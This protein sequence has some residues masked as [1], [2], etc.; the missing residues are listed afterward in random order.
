MARKAA[1]VE[2]EEEEDS[3]GGGGGGADNRLSISRCYEEELKKR[4]GRSKKC[5]ELQGPRI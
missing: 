2:E 1:A 3:G 4:V 5:H